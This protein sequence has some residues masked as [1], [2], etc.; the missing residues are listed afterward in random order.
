MRPLIIVGTLFFA[1]ACADHGATAPCERVDASR[2][3]EH[4]PRPSMD[5]GPGHAVDA[6][7][8]LAEDAGDAASPTP[9]APPHH[10]TRVWDRAAVE[11]FDIAPDDGLVVALVFSGELTLGGKKFPARAVNDWVLL[12]LDR[13][14]EVVWAHY[15]GVTTYAAPSALKVAPDGSFYVVGSMSSTTDLGGGPLEPVPGVDP[16]SAQEASPGRTGDVY[17]ARF[18]ADGAHLWSRRWGDA[19]AQVASGVEIAPD[20]GAIVAGRF[21]GRV[22]FGDGVRTA[23]HGSLGSDAFVVR[24]QPDGTTSWTV[25]L[26]AF[27]PGWFQG[28]ML[29]AAGATTVVGSFD[30]R[31]PLAGAGGRERSSVRITPAGVASARGIP[32]FIGAESIAGDGAG[33]I[34]LAGASFAA[35]DV[36]CGPLTRAFGDSE[37]YAAKFGGDGSCAWSRRFPGAVTVHAW[38]AAANPRGDVVFSGFFTNHIDFGGGALVVRT[39]ADAPSRW[40][41]FVV[42]LGPRGEHVWSVSA[43]ESGAN[44]ANLVKVDSEGHVFVAGK[45]QESINWGGESIPAEHG[46]FIAKL[47]P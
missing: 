6:S 21:A 45:C 42:K 27:D 11:A 19:S 47:G 39:D 8:V 44:D 18:D 33:G 26:R 34:A 28:P 23:S 7:I 13:A 1:V 46:A 16:W 17:V 43:G 5:G 35:D 36:G 9:H 4:N 30:P 15:F 22:D 14:G 2:I 41:A 24:L 3:L 31:E 20:G 10:W 32:R 40:D 37:L 29:D 25:Q 38:G 12:R